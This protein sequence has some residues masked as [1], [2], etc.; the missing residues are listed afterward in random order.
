MYTHTD[1]HTHTHTHTHTMDWGYE[2]VISAQADW[3][4]Q[5][6]N[7][8]IPRSPKP[9]PLENS[10]DI[11]I[12][13]AWAWSFYFQASEQ[14]FQSEVGGTAV[15]GGWLAVPSTQHWIFEGLLFP[16]SQ[17]MLSMWGWNSSPHQAG[18]SSLSWPVTLLCFAG[19]SN[20]FGHRLL[21][22]WE[23]KS[24]SNCAVTFETEVLLVSKEIK[25]TGMEI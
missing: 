13:G 18:P 25:P 9:V 19:H 1:T 14:L 3:S 6:W 10:L 24:H 22:L 7:R 8:V 17:S 15:V 23:L 20:W 12:V 11:F 21:S 2:A 5:T 16:H 4:R